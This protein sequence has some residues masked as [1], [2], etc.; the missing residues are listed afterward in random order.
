MDSARPTS[1]SPT[2]LRQ[3]D[4]GSVHSGSGPGGGSRVLAWL[5]LRGGPR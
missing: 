5:A 1:R 2:Q 4:S 3:P